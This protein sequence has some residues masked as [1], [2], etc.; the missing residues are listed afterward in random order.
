MHPRSLSLALAL[1]FGGIATVSADTVQL[2][3]GRSLAGKVIQKNQV[4]TI[5]TDRNELYQFPESEV[6]GSEASSEEKVEAPAP[7]SG[8]NPV[9]EFKTSMGSFQIE[10][11]EDDAP[12][13][14]ANFVELIEKEFYDG[15]V[16]HRVIE[17]FMIQGGDPNSKDAD[18]SND[19]MGG[20]GYRF[21][22][23]FSSQKHTGAGILSMANAGPKT[24]GSQF[25]ITLAPTPHLDGRHTVFG[26]VTKGLDIIKSIGKTETSGPRGSPPNRPKT[27]IK[28]ESAK[29]LSKRDHEY[30]VKKL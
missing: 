26:K 15:T 3:D 14:V 12:N 24:N 19:G 8:P 13:T 21:D 17:G 4:V 10:L 23:E 22:D 2:K 28:V 20:P 1:A 11:F 27:D 16:F 29:V 9:V 6:A 5:V 30:K 25:F 7:S 18:P